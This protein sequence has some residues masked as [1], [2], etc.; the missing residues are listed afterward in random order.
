MTL[1]NQRTESFKL[2]FIFILRIGKDIP[3]DY[4]EY[5]RRHSWIIYYPQIINCAIRA[6]KSL[7]NENNK[8]NK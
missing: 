4:T 5:I 7:I 6:T 3:K 2:F 8:N 1:Y